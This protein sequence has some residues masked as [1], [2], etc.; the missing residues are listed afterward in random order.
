MKFIF[1]LPGE[2][3]MVN[4][5]L[6][7]VLVALFCAC[8]GFEEGKT[9]PIDD[10]FKTQD[11]AFY[12]I[13]PD[14]KSLSYIKLQDK[15]P[16]LFVEDLA[17]G[18][19]LQLT[20][21]T[22]KT[23]SFY[24]WTSNDELIYYT[25]DD[26]KDRKSDLFVINKDGS[27]QIQLGSNEKARMDV[28][29]NQ[30]I[31]DKYIIVSSN[32]RDSSVFDVYRLNVRNGKMDIAAKNPGNITDWITD[33][34]GILKMAI[35]ND[36]VNK[37]LMYREN[38]S[39]PFKAVITNNFKTTLDPV[40]IA[41]DQ[42]DV[43]YAISN[44]NRDKNALVELD[45]K[46]GKEKKILFAND[47]LNVIEAKYSRAKKKMIFVTCETWKKEKFYLDST[48]RV[49]YNKIDALLPGTEWRVE[50]KDKLDNVFVVRTFTDKNPGSYYL[51]FADQN[52]L[53]KLADINSSIKEEDM[54]EMKPISYKSV[55][56]LTINGY[57]TLP[58]N[59]KASNLPLVVLPHDGPKWRNSWGYNADVQ[60]LANRGYAVLQV[61]YR[62]SI[63]YGK[64]FYAAGFKQ[65]DDKIQEDVNA[66]VRW[67]IEQKIVNSKKVAIYGNGF[68]GYIALNCLYKNPDLY[69]CGGSNSGVINLFSYFK[70]IPPFL[71]SKL[72]MYYEIVGNPITDTEYV[73]SA[74]PVFH[75]D[76]F[77]APVF[78]AQNPKDPHINIAE[79]IQFIKELQKRGVAVTH[80]EK[81]EGPD[82][83]KRQQ[84]R[85]VMYKALEQFLKDNINRK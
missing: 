11:K 28:I 16:N 5:V 67:L 34:K 18:K 64:T 74:S 45:L 32:K 65:L 22:E 61:N 42:P 6:I 20:H 26:S 63:G 80:I 19:S 2:N 71:K 84:S 13:S 51:Y 9:I 56:G 72:Q 40:A 59:K 48:I 35:A 54:C 36:G 44:V 78:I 39:Q 41:E 7:L 57:L 68:G 46:T 24:T 75:A 50:D 3:Y 52:K 17:T 21:L 10:F 79:G 47:T 33:N 83:I 4:R 23:L 12:H 25:R 77:R 58:K 60:F 30:L 31:D 53:R 15:K 85:L 66:G 37:T 1:V 38:E 62:G 29:E 55:D 8:K 70:M 27:K 43:L 69:S 14:G 82:P 49:N 76:R 73:R 81:E